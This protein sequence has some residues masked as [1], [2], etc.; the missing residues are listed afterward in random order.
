[1]SRL[2]GV[3][4]SLKASAKAVNWLRKNVAENSECELVLSDW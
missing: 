4:K 2:V 1:M 3:E